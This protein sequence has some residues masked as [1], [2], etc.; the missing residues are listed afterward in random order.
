MNMN[1]KKLCVKEKPTKGAAS[2]KGSSQL[3]LL[4]GSQTMAVSAEDLGN[5]ATSSQGSARTGASSSPATPANIQKRV[6]KVMPCSQ[7]LNVS[8]ASTSTSEMSLASSQIR[9]SDGTSTHGGIEEGKT[10]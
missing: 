6:A 8:A 3:S 1:N 4:K 5:S 10:V 9:D 7:D 2:R